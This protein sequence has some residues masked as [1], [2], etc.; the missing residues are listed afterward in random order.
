MRPR[1]RSTKV[2]PSVHWVQVLRWARATVESWDERSLLGA[3]P[4]SLCSLSWPLGSGV[5]Q[6]FVDFHHLE[7]AEA[8]SCEGLLAE[9]EVRHTLKQVS[10]NKSP[11]LDGLPNELYL[12][13]SHSFVPIFTDMFNYW[14]A[15]RA[16]PDCVTKDMITLLKKD[17]RHVWVDLDD[18]KPIILLNTELANRLQLV[19]CDLIGPE[20][21]YA[22]TGRS[23]QNNLHL[24]R[25]V[26]RGLKYDTK[27]T[28]INLD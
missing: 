25:E 3:L 21:N 10:L 27:A 15:Q 28:L 24:V 26:L 9:C 12:K 22:I 16:N 4:W 7:E 20:Q 14:F 23:I 5:S 6:L 11:G 17:G 2:S 8:A 13:M 19:I 1:V 18:Y